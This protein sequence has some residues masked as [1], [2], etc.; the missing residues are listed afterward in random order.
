[1]SLKERLIGR[2][3][4]AT[5]ELE[6]VNTVV[7]YQYSETSALVSLSPHLKTDYSLYNTYTGPLLD[8]SQQAY[9]YCLP[10]SR[11]NEAP[12]QLQ[13]ELY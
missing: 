12:R 7:Q 11:P 4:Q 13:G 8:Q 3:G 9:R 1:M 10:R 2:S 6:M 5:T